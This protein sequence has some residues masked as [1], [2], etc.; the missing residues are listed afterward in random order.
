MKKYILTL[1]FIVLSSNLKLQAQEK[2]TQ[3]QPTIMIIPWVKDGQDIRTILEDDFNKRIAIAKVK[4]AFDDRGFTTYDFTQKLKQAMNEMAL[5]SDEKTDLKAEIIRLSGADIIIETEVFVQK[6]ST[7]NSVKLILEGKDS[8]T[9]QSLS[10]KIGES[11]KFYTDDIAKLSKKAVES[12]IE[13]FLNTM[14]DKFSG[15]IENG[16]SIRINIGFI[17]DS[18]HNMDSEI[19]DEGDL[20]SDLLE[21]WMDVNAHNNNFHIQGVSE[22]TMVIDD[23]RIPLKD[24]KTGRNYR[25]T[26]LSSKLRKYIKN[27]LGLSVKQGKRSEAE[28]NII[29]Q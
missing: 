2:V 16:R 12:C 18:E 25:A 29:I 4:E 28:V 5:K 26:K 1:V 23:F 27:K 24:P 13:D 3:V 19:G 9:A 15:I 10:N 21:E 22:N 6:S 14:N 17:E 20:L 8:Y 11:G 7:G